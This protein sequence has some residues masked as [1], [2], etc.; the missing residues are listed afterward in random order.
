MNVYHHFPLVMDNTQI[1]AFKACPTKWFYKHCLHLSSEKS[2]HLHFGGAFAS[3]LETIRKGFYL[4]GMEAQDAL[5]A[6]MEEVDNFWGDPSDFLK[7][8]KNITSCKQ[9]LELYFMQFP[10]ATDIYKPVMVEVDGTQDVG[11]EFDFMEDLE[12]PHP[13]IDS[14]LYYT[15][16]VDM[17]TNSPNYGTDAVLVFDDKTTGGYIT[18]FL[19]SSWETRSQFTGYCHF[20]RKSG[21][22]ARGAVVSLCSMTK[23]AVNFERIETARSL[24]QQDI[25]YESMINTVKQM[26]ETYERMVEGKKKN[27]KLKVPQLSENSNLSESCTAY[28]RVCWYSEAC[29]R[30]SGEAMRLMGAEQNIWLPHE[31]KTT[32]LQAHMQ[33]LELDL[34]D[35]IWGEY[36]DAT[37]LSW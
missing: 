7:E 9:L 29:V 2:V 16:R 31:Q 5:S 25:W 37:T 3:A 4:Q 12:I 1:T 33:D 21:I 17:L 8:T 30:P 11:V 10:M 15:G 28:Y 27:P 32:N 18:P 20:L 23:S 14:P 22:R 35:F 34:N 26:K 24:Y 19:R 36:A 13:T 6:G